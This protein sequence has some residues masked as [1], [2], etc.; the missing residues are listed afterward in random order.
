MCN[1]KLDNSASSYRMI[2]KIAPLKSSDQF[3]FCVAMRWRRYNRGD[4]RTNF[5]K[6]INSRNEKPVGLFHE[7]PIE[8]Q[9]SL[10]VTG[11]RKSPELQQKFR[12]S[13]QMQQERRFEKKQAARNKKVEG[14]G[15]GDGILLGVASWQRMLLFSLMGLGANWQSSNL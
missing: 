5:Y 1:G 3:N 2:M 10:V 13:L 9:D 12:E 14:D 8:L 4:L 15:S 7:L 6:N 11:K